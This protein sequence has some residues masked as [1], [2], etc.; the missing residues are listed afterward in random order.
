[1]R[2]AL[3]NSRPVSGANRIAAV[4]LAILAGASVWVSLGIVAVT[5]AATMGRIA[6]MPPWWWLAGLA[7]AAGS[8]AMVMGLTMS[9]A[10]PLS[11]CVLLWL[12]Y[13]P[14]RVPAALMMW[15]GPLEGVVWLAMVIGMLA[16]SL[17]DWLAVQRVAV[18]PRRAPWVAGGLL[19]VV[20]LAAFGSV[21]QV[22]PGG[23]EPHYLVIAQSL[24]IDGDLRI[25]NN[26]ARGDYLS[27]FAGRL[28]PD[29]MTRGADAQIYSIHSPGLPALIL[30]A[31]ALAGYPGAVITV[32]LL[33][34]LASVLTWQ[35]AWI[36]SASVSGAWV[37][38]AAV[39]LS[40]PF[41][42]H[43]FTIY[44]DGPAALPVIAAVWVLV[45]LE[46]GRLVSRPALWMVGAGLA[47]LPWLHTR[48]ALIA[49]AAGLCLVARQ[50][51]RDHRR[52][53]LTALLLVPAVAAAAW[54]GYFWSIW[55]TV[56]PA[57]PYGA[58]TGAA[59]AYIGRGLTGLL[60][61]QQF[62]L[63]PA[64]P[65]YA[66]AM[67]GALALARTRPRLA[68][69]LALIAVPYVVVTASY[70]MWWGGIS[71][72][73]R[74]LVVLTPLAALP[75]AAWWP[76]QPAAARM[77]T[78]LLLLISVAAVWPRAWVDG[79]RLLYSDRS[80]YDLVLGWA[81]QTIDLPLAFPS[82]H[83][84]GTGGAL[85]DA[86]VWLI[87]GLVLVAATRALAARA[88]TA[89]LWTLV[90]WAAALGLMGSATVVWARHG[91]RVV[92]PSRSQVAALH[93]LRHDWLATLVRLRP[94][95]I[96]PAGEFL[97]QAAFST[98]DRLPPRAGDPTLFRAADLPAGDYELLMSGVAPAGESAMVLGRN[99]A[100]IERWSLDGRGPASVAATFRL[101]VDVASLA[102]RGD[103][104]GDRAAIGL[105]L[106]AAGL[107]DP[108]NKDGRRATRAARY[109]RARV[110][111][112]DERAYLEPAG[113]WTR[114]DGL[115]TLVI[116]TD[117]PD[118]VS[119]RLMLV[120][121]GAVATSVE[122]SVGAWSTRLSLAAGQQ[123]SVRLPP[124]NGSRAWA[125]T[126]HS[127]PGFRPSQV[128]PASD[129]V[130]LL[131]A[132]VELP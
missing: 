89:G 60:V 72:P 114:A 95:R 58:E 129:D 25:E 18:D 16:P 123:E 73:A 30:P 92:T 128:D 122:L 39:F 68:G 101:P 22:I 130:R 78:L 127:G 93:A 61:D 69:E 52:A 98:A 97:R 6:A 56:N 79:G 41:L 105:R 104:R 62:G 82:V 57:A 117:A 27:Y 5:S 12:P 70:A 124:L 38:W 132:W 36:L 106:R 2:S 86:G 94:F 87:V 3:R 77:L 53:S 24:L 31:F 19:A 26:H 76:R 107:A 44:P 51:V 50:A 9:R 63:L 11:L 80:G 42:F 33:A 23:D 59:V 102:I 20:S 17:P 4:A 35:A 45:S 108:V 13:L 8:I 65:I 29:Y 121:A 118:E 116:D 34:A 125:L 74:F 103:G 15:Q 96:L 37:G 90:V 40:S 49:V 85:R 75:I 111:V 110:F 32:A 88:A 131:A 14:G 109:G 100:P 81:A 47:A 1:M 119:G 83:R 55:R 66:C 84:D 48:F 43:A 91:D 64:A 115:A 7:A 112:F 28:R 126:I 46:A 21:R 67:I 99:D 71:S 120:R 113:F 54:F 10:W